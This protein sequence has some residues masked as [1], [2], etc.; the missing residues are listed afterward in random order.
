[1]SLV[2]PSR[3]KK[4]LVLQVILMAMMLSMLC[5]SPDLEEEDELAEDEEEFSLKQNQEWLVD[6]ETAGWSL[7]LWQPRAVAVTMHCCCLGVTLLLGH[8]VALAGK[9]FPNLVSFIGEL[10]QDALVRTLTTHV[11]GRVC[12]AGGIFISI[13]ISDSANDVRIIIK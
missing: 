11:V 9:R 7:L 2:N 10:C 6:P 4:N 12:S 8:Q 13:S 5:K 3:K 1:M